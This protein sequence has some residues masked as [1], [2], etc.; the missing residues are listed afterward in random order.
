MIKA[1]DFC[2][3]M[4][5]NAMLLIIDGHILLIKA[6]KDG[7]VDQGKL[8]DQEWLTKVDLKL[9]SLLL[10]QITQILSGAICNR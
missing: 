1:E 5:T 3:S 9:G 2:R 10:S 4:L 7:D 8:V 6:A